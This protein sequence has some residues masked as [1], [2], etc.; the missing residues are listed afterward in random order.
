MCSTDGGSGSNPWDGLTSATQALSAE[1][2]ASWSDAQVRQALP[3][4]LA[5]VNRLN[6]VV[7][8][9]AAS[10]DTRDL[11]EVDG[12]RTARSWLIGFGR[13]TQSAASGWLARG[14][15]MAQLPALAAAAHAGDVSAEQLRP[16]GALVDH[17]GIGAVAPFDQ[18]L[19]DLAVEA[20]PADVELACSRIRAHVDPDGPDPDADAGERRGLTLSRSGSLFSVAGRL[21]LEGGATVL[22]AIDALMRPPTPDDPRTA[23]QRR[24]DAMVELAR[25]ALHGGTLPTVGGSDPNSASC[26]P[27]TPSSAATTHPQ[28]TQLADPAPMRRQ[29]PTMQGPTMQGPTGQRPTGQRPTALPWVVPQRTVQRRRRPRRSAVVQVPAHRMRPE[30]AHPMPSNAPEYPCCPSCP[31]TPGHTSFRSRWLSGWPATAKGGAGG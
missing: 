24:A 1:Y 7:S 30:P 20:R 23:A 31:G 4:L 9:V 16:V 19:A 28:P 3:A 25:Q 29:G 10:F 27:P 26:S 11:A 17:V 2:V 15:L 14:R 13:M 21:D 5:E 22:T 8:T 6:A 12:F 18:I